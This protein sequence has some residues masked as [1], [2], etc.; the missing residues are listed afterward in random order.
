MEKFTSILK[1]LPDVNFL[2]LPELRKKMTLTDYNH[3]WS[4]FVAMCY[5]NPP[6]NWPDHCSIG[7]NL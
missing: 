2:I 5:L 1:N 3:K 4:G 7:G 6:I